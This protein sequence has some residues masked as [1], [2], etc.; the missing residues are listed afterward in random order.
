MSVNS[1]RAPAER[2]FASATDVKTT[3]AVAVEVGIS[4][5]TVSRIRK[6]NCA[7]AANTALTKRGRPGKL[8]RRDKTWI[9]RQVT[10]GQADNAV[11]V[12]KALRDNDGNQRVSSKTVRRALKKS[13]MKAIVKKKKPLLLPRHI[14]ARKR[15]VYSG[16]TKINRLGSD[17]REWV[18]KKAGAP[19][20]S[21]HVKGTL[22]VSILEDEFQ[23]SIDYYGPQPH[24][25]SLDASEKKLNSYEEAPKGIE[26][27]CPG[28][29]R[30]CIR[31]REVM[32]NIR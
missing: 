5:I 32:S 17:G 7:A 12:A 16:E 6:E 9:V 2:A 31:Q 23:Q 27:L 25:A 28:V 20:E 4:M 3:K 24:R 29:S 8:S 10:S 13:G 26:K 30:Q 21:R 1:D 15:V 22:Y 18:W 14:K 19:L 11:Q